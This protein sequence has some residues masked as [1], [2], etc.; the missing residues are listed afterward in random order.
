MGA[1]R[2]LGVKTDRFA[3]AAA[4]MAVMHANVTWADF[5]FPIIS[6]QLRIRVH[7]KHL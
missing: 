7:L 5:C 4:A 3:R 2:F 6:K 1:A